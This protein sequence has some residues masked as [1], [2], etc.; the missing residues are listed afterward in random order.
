MEIETIAKVAHEVNAA[1]C[2]AHGD[3]SQPSWEDAPDWQKRSAINGVVFH[4]QNPNAG[5]SRS[6]DNWLAE[7][8]ADGWV[9]GE[10]KNAEEKTHP[11]M[12]PFEELPVEQQA[13]DYLFRQVVHS[14]IA[15]S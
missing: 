13:K 5:P 2:L 8:E 12:V 6:H 7:K 11:C 1:F 3:T 10:E 9:Y 4:S 15:A 14:L